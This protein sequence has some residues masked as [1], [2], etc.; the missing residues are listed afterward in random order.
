MCV[1]VRGH[2]RRRGRSFRL[3]CRSSSG[4]P[5]I[6]PDLFVDVS[7]VTS[8]KPDLVLSSL[9]VPGHELVIA[10][11]KSANLP[12]LVVE[13]TSLEAFMRT[14]NVLLRLLAS[15]RAAGN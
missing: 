5:K 9:T 12:L 14:S 4:L 8:L 7:R 10:A 6:G 3:S 13:P 1:G 15:L 11:L 2:A